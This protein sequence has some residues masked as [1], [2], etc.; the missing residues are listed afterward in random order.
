MNKVKIEQLERERQ[1][2][3][4]AMHNAMDKAEAIK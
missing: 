2:W 4:W 1:T 3:I